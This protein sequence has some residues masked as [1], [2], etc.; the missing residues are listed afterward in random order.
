MVDHPLGLGRTQFERILTILR[1]YPDQAPAALATVPLAPF[2]KPTA[3]ATRSSVVVLHAPLK[4]FLE[5]VLPHP[6]VG[7]ARKAGFKAV[8]RQLVG[9]FGPVSYTHLTLPTTPYV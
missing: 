5:L 6:L 4:R 2:P 3:R 9:M 7:I 8:E 1:V